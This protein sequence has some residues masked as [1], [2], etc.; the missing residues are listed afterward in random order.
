MLAGAGL[1]C[2]MLAWHGVAAEEWPRFLAGLT[3]VSAD[4]T[5]L[6][7][8]MARRVGPTI[9]LAFTSTALAVVC[10]LGIAFLA[11]RIGRGMPWVAGFCGRLVAVFPVVAIAW[12][13]VGWIIGRHGWP[14]ESLL[15]H[16][17]APD[18]DSWHLDVARRLWFWLLPCWILALPLCGE[19]VS[20]LI[21]QHARAQ[22]GN[23][24]TGLR[25]RG[26][27]PSTI[28]YHHVLPALWPGLFDFILA[29][30][31]LALGYAIFVEEALGIQGWGAFF[32]TAIQ[33]GDVRAVA[34]CVYAAGWMSACWC[35]LIG[36]ARSFAIHPAGG[37]GRV[38]SALKHTPA[39]P[40]VVGASL[41]LTV[42]AVSGFGGAPT[43]QDRGSG[44]SRWIEP[45]TH[46]LRA[47]LMIVLAAL[48]M[49]LARGGIA[50]LSRSA[51]RIPRLGLLET[52]SWSPLLAWAL[53]FSIMESREPARWMILALAA[54]F[55]GAVVVRNRWRELEASLAVEASRAAGTG[56]FRAWHSHV[57]PEL[58]RYLLA[59][60]LR[61]AG[62][63]LVW[64]VLIDSLRATG[65]DGPAGSLGLGIA[66][67][68]EDVPAD[69]EPLILPAAI[70]AI[71]AL[72]F[73]QAS[74]IVAPRPPVD[75]L[76]G[77]GP[78]C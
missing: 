18:H 71:C 17:P 12:G 42:I 15:P 14:I 50:C 26:L 75:S 13:A 69:L 58:W 62:T 25:A 38:R 55:G 10:G 5:T 54:A 49:A 36:L 27:K 33:T 77:R 16:H 48:L 41:M 9:L 39:R 21:D 47:L 24:V 76:H 29:L 53:G 59:W 43:I 11:V 63:L 4:G 44:A 73:R 78:N 56:A 52:L 51:A 68:K 3:V 74:R 70:T 32:A 40:A 1:A 6:A 57:W 64:W 60:L 46:D 30:G 20:E 2:V 61:A 7:G 45:L 22:R 23:L 37:W 35:L 66:R 34:G 28:H 72:C 31:F 65:V 19:F 67:A 8:A